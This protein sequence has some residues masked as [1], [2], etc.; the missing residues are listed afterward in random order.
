M[1]VMIWLFGLLFATVVMVAI[2]DRVGLPWPVLLTI[3]TAGVIF[4]PGVPSAG[5]L[6]QFSHLMLPIFIPPLLWALARRASWAPAAASTAS[7][8][9]PELVPESTTRSHCGRRRP[10]L[11]P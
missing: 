5:S 2:G 6:S 7:P 9:A 3:V 8:R 10:T 1:S 11:P 4:I